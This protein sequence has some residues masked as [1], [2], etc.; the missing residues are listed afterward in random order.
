MSTCSRKTKRSVKLAIKHLFKISIVGLF[1]IF[2]IFGIF[3]DVFGATIFEDDFEDYDLGLL[4]NQQNWNFTPPETPTEVV[5]NG[6]KE[7]FNFIHFPSRTFGYENFKEGNSIS[8]GSVG[9]WFQTK[10]LC[11]DCAFLKFLVRSTDPAK[12]IGY[13]TT[14]FGKAGYRDSA[15]TWI[16]L[17]EIVDDIW[18]SVDIEWESPTAQVRYNFDSQGWTDWKTNKDST[19]EEPDKISLWFTVFVSPDAYYYLDFIAETSEI[20]S[21]SLEH[22]NLCETYYTCQNVGCCWYY[23]PWLQ[24]NFCISCTIGECGSGWLECP[25]CLN[26][27]DCELQENCYWFN[28][29]CK[30]GLGECGE[31]L[32][33]QFCDTLETCEAKNCYWYS[34]F[35]W[36]DEP[37]GVSSW[38]DY[39]TT[40]GGYETPLAFVSN[41]ASLTENL[42]DTISGLLVGFVGAFDTSEAITQGA[43]FGSVIPKARG[44]LAIFNDF[45]GE[46]PVAQMF[47]FLITFLIA[48]GVF[49][50]VRNLIALAKFW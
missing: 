21:C 23:S 39:Y 11:S 47:L 3:S 1:F 46:L 41:M 45:F 7:G 22:C 10:N 18:Y 12:V 37:L 50:L 44:Y 34:D 38:A 6:A 31:G 42:F 28:G 49:R 2:G 32:D 15:N 4:G 5:T 17:G 25:N 27:I 14:Q 43:N 20:P 36:I 30:F 48:I 40:H 33:C 19:S 16:E 9:F 35:C 8:V 13:F 29:L 26:K 24:E